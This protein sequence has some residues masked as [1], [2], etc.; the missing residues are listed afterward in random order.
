MNYETI[1]LD[2]SMYKGGESF[3]ARL[4]QLD[5]SAVYQGTPLEG[6]DAYQRQLKRFDIRV[7]GPRSSSIEKFFSTADSAALF[8]E[9]VTRAVRQGMEEGEILS[10]ILA[11]RTA[12]D[13]MDYRSIAL[14][15]AP[16]DLELKEVAEGS[17]IPTT[18]I[19]LKESLVK[20]KKRGRM[21]SASYEAIRFQRLDLFTA[22]LRQIG[23]YIAK[24]QLADAV[25]VL[26]NGDGNEGSA[27][28]VTTTTG[29]AL[30]YRDLVGMWQRFDGYRM[31]TLLAS[32]D[33]AAAI[34]N[35]PEMVSPTAGLN[36]QATGRLGTPLGAAL[37][38]SSAVP[39]G[40]VI[41]LDSRSALEM[42]VAGEVNVDH[43]RLIDTQLERAAVTSIAGFAKL[44]P[45][46]V[47]VLKLKTG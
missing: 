21:L 45:G 25:A 12:I 34:L 42:V 1:R 4:E 23:S 17:A 30:A 24:S 33:M 5:P 43:D 11:S 36:F 35:L 19:K 3:S 38:K 13:S 27:A 28:A 22:A 20:L 40:T 32:P 18:E 10:A 2:K 16:E 8:P 14:G 9:Y 29:E 46:A 39:A 31:D 37:L 41:A 47:Q 15:E 26:M 6:L 44:F 7:S